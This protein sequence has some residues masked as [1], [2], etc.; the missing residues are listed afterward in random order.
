MLSH[1]KRDFAHGEFYVARKDRAS[2]D[3]NAVRITRNMVT[4]ENPGDLVIFQ[5]GKGSGWWHGMAPVATGEEDKGGYVRV[6]VGMLQS[7]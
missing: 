6:A 5:A 7:T 3:Q 4:F 2:A 1:P